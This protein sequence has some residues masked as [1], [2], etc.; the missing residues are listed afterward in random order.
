[1]SP[2]LTRKACAFAVFT[3]SAFIS[4]IP[5]AAAMAFR[6]SA[7]GYHPQG[8]KV[9]ILEDVPE[10]QKIEVVLFD[11]T[12]RN[13]KFPVLLGATVYKVDNIQAFQDE[14]QQG[15]GTKNL[16][17]DFSDFQLP[18]TYELRVEG[19]DVK[20]KPVQ[21]NDYLYWDNLKPVVRSFYFQRC[22]SEI[23]DRVLKI[24]RGACHL[25]DA[26]Q[27]EESNTP[28][29]SL[30]ET[31]DV[32]GGWHNGSDYAKYVTSTALS[33]AR[34]MAMHEWGPKAFQYFRM[35]YPLFEPGYGVTDDLHHEVKNGL[36][37]L[38]TMQRKDGSFYRKVAGKKWPGKVGPT[39]DEQTRYVYGITTQDTASAAA[40]FAMAVRDFKS[41]DLG[42]SVKALRAA[43]KAWSFLESHPGVIYQRSD[44]DFS[45]SGEFLT[46]KAKGDLP[47]R[48]WAAAELYI[49]TGKEPYHRYFLTHV[50]DVPLQRFTWMNPAILGITNYLLYAKNQDATVA[51]S[52]KNNILRL[53]DGLKASMQADI[54]STGLSQFGEGSNPEIA[55]RIALL[56]SAYRLSGDISYRQAASR[57]VTYFYGMNPLAMTYITGMEGQSVK[58]PAHRWSQV[59]DKVVPGLLVDGP[60]EG[61][62]DGSTPKGLGARSYVDEAKATGSNESRILNNASLAFVLAALNDAYNSGP[63]GDKEKSG[64]PN[65]PLNFKLAPERLRPAKKGGK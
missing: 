13:P 12:K 63:Q 26:E 60:N 6:Q 7:I 45:G 42:Y 43:E 32:V 59:M 64:D 16:L 21:I 51:N 33:A 29:L 15:P 46:P 39:D 23:E 36:E 40:V 31:L 27:L 4:L 48:L 61:A 28:R 41:I 10:D 1:M 22:G 57:S 62:T 2:F 49:S 56:L 19:S 9:A 14:T 17:L 24:Y 54:Y 53:A 11:P 5:D 8:A 52:L 38:L 50:G 25:R 35:D 30:G 55:E 44:I 37:W 18:G 3:L 34:L 47:Y 20:S 65:S 58:Y